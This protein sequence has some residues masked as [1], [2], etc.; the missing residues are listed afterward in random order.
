MKAP[1]TILTLLFLSLIFFF[2]N[3]SDNSQEPDLIPPRAEC[4]KS[5]SNR[6]DLHTPEVMVDDWGDPVP[7][8]DSI[9]NP[10]PQD[11]IEISPDGQTLYFLFMQDLFDS[12]TTTEIISQ[13]NGTYAAPR[14]GGPGE[15]GTPVFFYLG[16][17]SGGSLDGEPSFSPDGSK[18]YFHSLRAANTG[19]Q[20][21]PP[22]DDMLDIYVADITDGEPGAGVNLGP[23][24]NSIY[25]DGEHALHPDGVT[26]FFSSTRPGGIGN[27]DI[28]VTTRS[29]DIWSAP[30]N[31]GEPVN[32]SGA[33]LQPAF[34]ADGDT[35]YFTSDRDPEIGKAI[36]RSQR[37]GEDWSEPE[38]VIKGIVGEASLTA[39]GDYL[40]F[41]HVL[42]DANG[43]FDADVWYC[44]RV[45]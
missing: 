15:F 27:T 9:N 26:L 11:A 39:D 21:E 23:I 41:V 22:Q 37:T 25:A 14:I 28:W 43:V 30:V 4:T 10:C 8:G 40:Y 16:K 44:P 19:Y 36:Y 29:G 31:L 7:V 34:T 18:V 6:V 5:E 33:D 20:Q 24:V 17:G 45:E 38:L 2:H 3:C 42:S 12:L 32:S 35:M 1:L 13:P